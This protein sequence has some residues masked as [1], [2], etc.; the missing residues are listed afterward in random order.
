[1]CV[2]VIGRVVVV[3]EI[4]NLCLIF[5]SALQKSVDD[6]HP[7]KMNYIFGGKRK[8]SNSLSLRPIV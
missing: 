1:V 3:V 7:I 2:F 4:V 5:F 8:R 6:L